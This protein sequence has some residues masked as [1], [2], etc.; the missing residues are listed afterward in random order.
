MPTWQ[1]L[2]SFYIVGSSTTLQADLTLECQQ[3]A[4][5][6]NLDTQISEQ[7]SD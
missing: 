3:E 1:G 4:S 6:D 2:N 7:V 5:I